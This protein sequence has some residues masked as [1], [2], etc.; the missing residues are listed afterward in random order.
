MINANEDIYFQKIKDNNLNQKN[1]KKIYQPKKIPNQQE[2]YL[3]NNKIKKINNR[4]YR[5]DSSFINNKVNDNID[6]NNNY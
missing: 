5:Y 6:Q 3:Y 4:H 1:Y 2:E